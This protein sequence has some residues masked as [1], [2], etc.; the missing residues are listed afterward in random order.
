MA[1]VFG[2]LLQ[3][4]AGFAFLSAIKEPSGIIAVINGYFLGCMLISLAGFFSSYRLYLQRE[5]IE[6]ANVESLLAMGW[7]PLWWFGGGIHEIDA[8]VHTNYRLAYIISFFSISGL[9]GFVVG[10]KLYW[11]RLKHVYKIILPILILGGGYSLINFNSRPSVYGGYAAWPLVFIIQYWLL[12]KDDESPFTNLMK[13]LHLGTFLSLITLIT[14]EIAWWSDHMVRG[15]G[16][17]G[18]VPW[19]VMPAIFVMFL[20]KWHCSLS[21]PVSVHKKTYLYSGLVPVV[22]CLW[23]GTIFINLLSKGDPWPISYAPLLNPLDLSQA[24][25]LIAIFFWALAVHK[26]FSIYPF[27]LSRIHLFA[28][29]GATVFLWLNAILI[30]TLHYWGGVSFNLQSMVT[31]DLVQ[32]SLSIFWTLSAF[33]VMLW[34]KRKSVRNVWI[35]G[36]GLIGIVVIK[37]FLFDLSN[38]GT[39]ERIVSFMGVGGICLL[40]GYLAPMPPRIQEAAEAE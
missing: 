16:I 1:R 38:T 10:E 22:T 31:S 18:L 5:K 25:V 11:G 3:V 37:L 23:L 40:I 2:L 27:N 28:T 32:T 15:G 33:A 4:L 36:A 21:W 35:G 12:Y 30:R 7:A 9:I 24:F 29:M 13:Y 19:G 26:E 17:W 6:T 34:G 14:W 8:F 39:V 20:S